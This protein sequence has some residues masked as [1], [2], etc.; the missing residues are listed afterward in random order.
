[1]FFLDVGD[2]VSSLV[3]VGSELLNL[4]RLLGQLFLSL[5]QNVFA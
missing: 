5:R 3:E 4:R 1:M 2:V